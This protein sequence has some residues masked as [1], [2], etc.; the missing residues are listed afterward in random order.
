MILKSR[1]LVTAAL[2][3]VAYSPALAQID[4]EAQSRATATEAKMTADERTALTHGIMAVPFLPGAV[5]PKE[6]V[7]GAGYVP[8]ITRLGVPA[9]TETDA[10]LGVSYLCGVRGPEGAT[11]P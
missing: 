2:S 9:L 10:S 3:L 5:I 11:P 8:G 4:Q 1:L 7:L 6:A